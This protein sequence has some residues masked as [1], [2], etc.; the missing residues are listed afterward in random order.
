M[1]YSNFMFKKAFF[2]FTIAVLIFIT[3]YSLNRSNSKHLEFAGWSIKS[4]AG[5]DIW[6]ENTLEAIIVA[7]S[8]SNYHLNSNSKAIF[9]YYKPRP[10]PHSSINTALDEL[11]QKSE[12][13]EIEILEINHRQWL[14][15]KYTSENAS[16]YFARTIAGKMQYYNIRAEGPG[17]RENLLELLKNT[18]VAPTQDL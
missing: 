14:T 2:I 13:S 15:N 6:Q 3:V 4:P 16:Y 12:N 5:W 17:I 18:S 8:R 10:W 9:I 7:P 1:T 11:K